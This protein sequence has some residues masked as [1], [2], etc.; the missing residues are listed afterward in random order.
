MLLSRGFLAACPERSRRGAHF[1][2]RETKWIPAQSIAGMTPFSRV[3]LFSSPSAVVLFWFSVRVFRVFRGPLTCFSWS[4]S[5]FPS[6]C[7]VVQVFQISS[8]GS[9]TGAS[10]L[11]LPSFSCVSCVSWS[12]SGFPS[13]WSVVE[14]LDFLKRI[15]RPTPVLIIER[16][17]IRRSRP[18]RIHPNQLRA[19][20]LE[21]R[22][23][24]VDALRH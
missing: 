1:D 11:R 15:H 10:D 18:R 6:V 5:G 2:L 12:S 3:S 7:S 22:D 23:R 24:R 20:R 17:H 4:S 16:P 8:N 14:S 9:P 13:V 21:S 19:H